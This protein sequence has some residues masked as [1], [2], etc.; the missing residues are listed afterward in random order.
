MP[1]QTFGGSVLVE[2]TTAEVLADLW[3]PPVMEDGRYIHESSPPGKYTG[4][5]AITMN[6]YGKGKAVFLNNNIFGAYYLRPQWNLKN[7]FR[8]LLN[9]VIA[10]KL[11][12]IEAP[13]NVEVVLSEK[14]GAKQVHL[15]NHYRDKSIGNSNTIVENVLPVHN[16]NIKVKAG[17][18]AGSV[19]L[20]PEN[21]K[22]DFEYNKGYVSFMI[23]KLHIYSIAVIK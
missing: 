4:S 18:R 22:L 16:I 2:E 23:P 11:I 15:V 1:Q 17:E 8:N 21:E 9:E 10:E 5:P 19:K 14:G 20:M 7:M 12:E 3:E 13:S 6:V